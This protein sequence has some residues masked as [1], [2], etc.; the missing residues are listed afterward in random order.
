MFFFLHKGTLN[1]KVYL[2]KLE[3]SLSR[4]PLFSLQGID[5][6]SL[7][8]KIW[9]QPVL[10]YQIK[11]Q[12]SYKL[13][14]CSEVMHRQTMSAVRSLRLLCLSDHHIWSLYLQL[15]NIFH[16]GLSWSNYF[17]L[18]DHSEQKCR[19]YLKISLK[20][21]TKF[22]TFDNRFRLQF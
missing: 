14:L 20:R 3:L 4:V 1:T 8:I 13:S 11:T 15:G 2:F 10:F 17:N 12:P 19:E 16:R 18:K 22:F 5:E 7:E 21:E 6:Q 9:G